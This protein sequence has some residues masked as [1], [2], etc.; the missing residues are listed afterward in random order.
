M[1]QFLKGAL[2]YL[3]GPGKTIKTKV[4]R[5]T[6]EADAIFRDFHDSSSGAHTGQKNPR[7]HLEEIILA[8]DGI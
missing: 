5:G 4:V 6:E 2:Y 1:L 3:R 7:C 8:W